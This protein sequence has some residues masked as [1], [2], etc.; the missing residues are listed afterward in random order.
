MAGKLSEKQKEQ[1]KDPKFVLALRAVKPLQAVKPKQ[2]AKKK[3]TR[4]VRRK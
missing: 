1:L 3:S 2:N 4:Q